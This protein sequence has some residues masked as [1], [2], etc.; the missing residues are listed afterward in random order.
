MYGF[1]LQ[2]SFLRGVLVKAKILQANS[3]QSRV[4]TG[5]QFSKFCDTIPQSVSITH[6]HNNK[7][8]S[9][10]WYGRS[11]IN[12]LIYFLEFNDTKLCVG[13]TRNRIIDMFQSHIFNTEHMANTTVGI[14]F[15][16]H[17]N[18]TDQKMTIHIIYHNRCLG[19]TH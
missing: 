2:T 1:I 5:P 19:P 6:L 9:T 15:A 12:N 3:S 7:I 13:Q 4:C 17:M 14:H 18:L 8:Y 11:Q 16:N 10:I